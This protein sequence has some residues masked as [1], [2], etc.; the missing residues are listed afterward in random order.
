MD[1]IDNTGILRW[2]PEAKLKFKNVPFFARTQARKMIEE[3]ARNTEDNLVTVEIVEQARI[4][5]GQ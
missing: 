3:I 4:N 2:T 5:F 1:N